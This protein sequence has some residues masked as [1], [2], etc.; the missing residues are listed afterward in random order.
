MDYHLSYAVA[1]ED[2]LVSVYM[3]V[4]DRL[5]ELTYLHGALEQRCLL[6]G[7]WALEH[8]RASEG[9]AFYH[10]VLSGECTLRLPGHPDT[11]LVAGD[12]AM[13]PRGDAHLLTMQQGEQV[14]ADVGEIN[15]HFNGAVTVRTNIFSGAPSLDL[16][17]GRFCYTPDALLINVLPDIVNIS[18]ER[19]DAGVLAAP[20]GMQ[21]QSRW[22]AALL[23]R[24]V[25]G[26]YD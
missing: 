3:D 10:V 9:E 24:H 1:W 19:S 8:P 15:S 5:I 22:W 14:D 11:L 7:E 2:F 23:Q 25:Q 4:F 6:G 12:V 18:F 17:C 13:L 21:Y 16:L 20:V 26:R